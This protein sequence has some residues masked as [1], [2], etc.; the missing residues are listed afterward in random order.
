MARRPWRLLGLFGDLTGCA[1]LLDDQVVRVSLDN[2]FE[3]GI[4]MAGKDEEEACVRARAT[5]GLG[6]DSQPLRAGL[7]CALTN[8]DWRGRRVA[9]LL[10]EPRDVLIDLAEERLVAGSPLLP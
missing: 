4:F 7:V 10:F 3:L 9:V 2:A 6:I 8:E 5:I 1:G